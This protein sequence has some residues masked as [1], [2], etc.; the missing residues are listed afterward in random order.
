MHD[1]IYLCTYHTHTYTYVYLC[2]YRE[3]QETKLLCQV[4]PIR[5]ETSHQHIRVSVSVLG[6]GLHAHVSSQPEWLLEVAG[7]KRVV[8]HHHRLTGMGLHY[9]HNG[10]DVDEGQGRI[11]RTL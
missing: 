11:G 8:H 1:S 7:H 9:R 4:S 2:T 5:H 3:L 10:R 6:E